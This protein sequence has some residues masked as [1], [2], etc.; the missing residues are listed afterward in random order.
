[1][2]AEAAVLAEEVTTDPLG[3]T[4]GRGPG[5]RGIVGVPLALAAVLL[6]LWAWVGAQDLD[7][8]EQRTL[9][10]EYVRTAVTQHLQLTFVAAFFVVILA[11]PTGIALTR[12]KARRLTPIV[13]A[14]ANGGQAI[15]AIGLL[16]LLTI[17]FGV[18]FTIAIIGLVA[19]SV[20]PVLRNTIAGVQQVD[21]TLV[22]A[23][24]GMGLKPLQVLWR[25]EIPL[26]VPVMLAGLRTALV[27]C[28]GV[29]TLATF[30]DAGGLGDMIINGLKLQR[31]VVEVTGAV[32]TC[33]IAFFV[34]WLGGV[35]ERILRPRGL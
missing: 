20:L 5:W 4:P 23:A 11:V 10:A 29:A 31:T 32:L 28:V 15:P 7:A 13:L 1:M 35:V 6:A 30:V 34:D 9:N 18:G 27:L 25:I 26:A 3:Q 16:V 8:I 14:L 21:P 2:S 12:P 22:E 33:A 19:S 24:R 17:R